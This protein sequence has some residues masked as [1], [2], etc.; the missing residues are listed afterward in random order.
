MKKIVTI[1]LLSL[2]VMTTVDAQTNKRHARTKKTQKT[3]QKAPSKK[4]SSLQQDELTSDS[5]SGKKSATN[6]CPNN[7][8]PHAI[9]LDLPSGTKWACCNVGASIPEEYG[10]YYAWGETKEKKT[11]GLY[12]YKYYNGSSGERCYTKNF[13]YLCGSDVDVAHVKWGDNWQ[14][15]TNTQLTE[16]IENCIHEFVTINGVYG[17]KFIGPNGNV[18]FLPA[19]G[20]DH[21]DGVANLNSMGFYCPGSLSFGCPVA[22]G[23]LDYLQFSEGYC[24]YRNYIG[25]RFFGYSVRPVKE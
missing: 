17:A 13:D 9:D 21:H 25:D 2:L 22:Y 1:I 3:V 4:T 14:M 15:P 19:A 23:G 6:F 10:G 5:N 12:N 16:L 24:E 8:H 7:K 20:I 11:H 18:I